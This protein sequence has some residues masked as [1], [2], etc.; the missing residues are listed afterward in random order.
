[1]FK[2]GK[3]FG[4]INIIDLVVLL[5][6]VLVLCVTFLRN[7]KENVVTEDNTEVA[8][9][10]NSFQYTLKIEYVNEKTGMMF[11]EGDIVYDATSS[12]KIG[13]IVKVDITPALHEFVND[14]GTIEQK[15]TPTRIDILLT[16]K[17]DGT[18]KNEEYLAGGLIKILAGENKKIKTKYASCLSSVVSIEKVVD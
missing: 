9:S 15:E 18:V 10:Q 6:V 3:L 8:T 17:T 2:D 16:V 7:K 5:I 11:K 13:E 1:M 14:D 12:T 4:K